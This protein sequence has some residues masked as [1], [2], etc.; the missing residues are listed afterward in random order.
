[1]TFLFTNGGS[2]AV[3]KQQQ[4]DVQTKLCVRTCPPLLSLGAYPPQQRKR[5]RRDQTKQWPWPCLSPWI[6]GLAIKYSPLC[7]ADRP[8][9]VHGML[10]RSSTKTHTFYTLK[11]TCAHTL[12]HTDTHACRQ[13]HT[14]MHV[15][16]HKHSYIYVYIYI[17][18]YI[19]YYT[20]SRRNTKMS[21]NIQRY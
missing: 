14:H 12:P 1:M 9:H 7:A 10:N 16:T 13:T 20:G 4:T 11:H 17:Y 19:G 2:A 6:R 5:K 18:I 8:A 3:I 15:Q 21:K